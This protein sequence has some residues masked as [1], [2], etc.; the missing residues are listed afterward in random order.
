M[1]LPASSLLHRLGAR[2]RALFLRWAHPLGTAQ[3]ARRV[4]TALTHAGGATATLLAAIVPLLFHGAIREA[5]VWALG[6]L[7]LSHIAVQMVKRS[8]GRPR[9]SRRESFHALV[10]EPDKF[11]FPSGHAA[12]A[13]SVA[14]GYGV[15]FPHAVFP[16]VTLAALVGVSRVRLGVHYPGDVLAGQAIAIATGSLLLV[17]R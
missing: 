16:L 5:G 12:A 9:P 8:V 3:R 11:S 17:T 7:V 2:D 15:V 6:T 14:F 13:M 4:W 10:A 1:I